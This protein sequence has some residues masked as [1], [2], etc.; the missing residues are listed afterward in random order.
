M[1]RSTLSAFLLLFLL[2]PVAGSAQNAPPAGSTTVDSRTGYFVRLPESA[3]LDP[4]QSGWSEKGQYEQRVYRIE[5]AGEIRFTSTVRATKVPNNST[6]TES[7]VYMD[8]DSATPSGTAFIRT[9]YLPTRNVRIE[10]IP[11]GV[12]MADVI[13]TRQSI[14]DSFRWKPG[15]DSER[16][17][18]DKW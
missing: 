16:V 7:Y 4:Q 11:Y 15:A 6:V 17:D 5:G 8:A 13:A 14:F 1:R 12:R 3:K 18:V 2:L 9:Y 10:L